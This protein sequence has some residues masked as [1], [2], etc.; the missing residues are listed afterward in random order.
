[1]D[2]KIQF[3][4]NLIDL[5]K[6]LRKKNKD[7][8]II[9]EK[10]NKYYKSYSNQLETNF[11][12][13]VV[14]FNKH[15]SKYSDDI[16]KCEEI[17]FSN[18]INRNEVYLLED[19]DFKPLWKKLDEE[20]K[21]YVWKKLKLLY[22]LSIHILKTTT[23]Y[24]D[25]YKKQKEIMAKLIDGMTQK[26]ALEIEIRKQKEEQ[27]LEDKINFEEI[28]SKFGDN[29]FT[30]IIIEIIKELNIDK[31]VN[32]D[33]LLG[34]I[35][36]FTNKEE[37]K[38]N[39][40]IDNIINKV[41]TKL[42]ERNMTENELYEELARV[43]DKF[44]DFFKGIPQFSDLIDKLTSEAKTIIDNNKMNSNGTSTSTSTSTGTSTNNNH[45][46]GFENELDILKDISARLE[47]IGSSGIIDELI[48]NNNVN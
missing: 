38:V 15:L 9:R 7:N 17:M 40:L 22:T 8:D 48:K 29:I 43:K 18:D 30:D 6:I 19:I 25:L 46:Q 2:I 4:N 47:E 3:N 11:V 26:H 5:I 27:E 42:V 1:M 34:L 39:P 45:F 21:L 20:D 16:I 32:A 28:R 23:E 35:K 10:L 31:N 14:I 41:K 12:P 24:Q 36:N 37:N 44:N 33:A 13:F